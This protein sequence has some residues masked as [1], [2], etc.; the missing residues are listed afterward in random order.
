MQ[1]MD[2]VIR[3]ERVMTPEG[4]RSASI[5]IK[6]GRIQCV[7]A[8]DAPVRARQKVRVESDV[9]VLPGLVDTHVHLQDPGQSGWEGFD[10]GTRAAA[11]GGI[12]T[13]VDMPLDSLPVTVDTPSLDAKRATA[14]GRCHVDVGFWGGVTPSNI[15]H[16]ADLHEAGVLGFKCFLANTGIPEFPPITP[17]ELKAALT[18]INTFDGVLAVHAED[19]A[20][21]EDAAGRALVPEG[22]T[23]RYQDF[24]A[25]QPPR[26]EDCAVATVIEATRAVAGRSHIVHVSSARAAGLIRNARAEGV[27]VTAE[28]CPHYLALGAGE[29]PDGD[30][31]FKV[32]P[33]IREAAN[34]DLLWAALEAGALQ[35][36][37]SD[38]SPCAVEH[39]A[40]A[41]GDF[42]EAFGGI[43]SLQISLPVVWT[44][45]RRRGHTLHD[46]ATWMAR[47][48]AAFIGLPHKGAIAPGRDADLCFVAPEETFTVDPAALQHRQPITPYAGREL[49]G[50]V[51][52][53]WLR[54]QPVDF[55][56]PRGQLLSSA[57]R[58]RRP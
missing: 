37:V 32:C 18:E 13:V 33:P 15:P 3:A 2:T 30:T 40:L 4:E 20:E 7:E 43:S 8:L 42:T 55:A 57:D 41:H 52:Q 34:A 11:A 1:T 9:V 12:T 29:V 49:Y 46:V 31:S 26:I 6:Q 35:M 16:L 56:H 47:R 58:S 27:A 38:H 28:T 23:R 44:E 50:V 53:T 24:L 14:H 19:A 10:S 36:I 22:R 17:E 45:A 54:G 48:P 25:T 39:K 5:G 21:M 51:R